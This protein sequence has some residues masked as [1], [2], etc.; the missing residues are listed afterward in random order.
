MCSIH[1][2]HWRTCT[3]RYNRRLNS[4]HFRP[5]QVKTMLAPKCAQ[6]QSYLP[7]GTKRSFQPF[8]HSSRQKDSILYNGCPFPKNCPYPS[9]D[10]DQHLTHYSLGPSKPRTQAAPCWF[11]RLCTDDLRVSLY[12]TIGCPSPSKLPLSMGYLNRI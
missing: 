3:R 7:G 11:N 5:L 4:Q 6:V 12:F 8:L 1:Q 9:G 10:L 2:T